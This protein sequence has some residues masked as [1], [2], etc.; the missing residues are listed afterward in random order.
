[1]KSVQE[2]LSQPWSGNKKVSATA[3]IRL[4][5]SRKEQLSAIYKA[6]EPETRTGLTVRSK[7]KVKRED[8]TLTLIF[9]AR[10]TAALRAALNSYLHWVLLTKDVLDTM[11]TF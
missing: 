11:K 2:S 7:V 8:K 4:K 10:D 9:E 6:L 3:T 5:F 1:M